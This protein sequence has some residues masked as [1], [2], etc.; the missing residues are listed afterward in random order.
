MEIASLV[1]GAATAV[2][3]VYA[4]IDKLLNTIT[5]VRHHHGQLRQLWLEILTQKTKL[6]NE[7]VLLF[8]D[9]SG[10]RSNEIKAM[11]GNHD[12]PNWKDGDFQQKL[13][14]HL[15]KAFEQDDLTT[16]FQCSLAPFELIKSTVDELNEE[17]NRFASTVAE[18]VT[19]VPFRL[20]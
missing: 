9:G 10:C 5:A 7:C 3:P 2:I 11:L 14:E 12:H 18:Q 15:G 16:A 1:L 17:L 4:G 19:I 8:G 6:K 13:S 20:W